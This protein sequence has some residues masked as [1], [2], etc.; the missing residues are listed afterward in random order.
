MPADLKPLHERRLICLLLVL[1]PLALFFPV[2]SHSFINFDDD[3]YVTG[4]VHVDTGLTGS[5]IT[6]AFRSG[7]AHNWHP[8]TWISHMLDC[9]LYGLN[10]AGHH[11]TNLLLHIA[12]TV[13]IFLFLHRITGALWRSGFVAALF[14]CHPIHVESVA[15][16]AERKDVL[17]TLFW[18]LTLLAYARF[19]EES[20]AQYLKFKAQSL[21]SKNPKPGSKAQSLKPRVFYSAAL[22]LFA[23][24]LMSKPMVVTLPFVLLL[25]D[26]WPFQRFTPNG[27]GVQT[28]A[29]QRIVVE[30]I[31]FFALSL[32]S[33]TV[34]F[35]A[36]RGA[37][38]T[39]DSLPLSF[40]LANAAVSCL[41]YVS[42]SIW[43][44]DLSVF[45]P[46]PTHWPPG[47][48][49]SSVIFVLA[50]SVLFLWLARRCPYLFVGWYWFLGTLIPVIGLVQVGLQSMADRYLYIPS[51]GLFL[52]IVW[53][54][55]AFSGN[56]PHKKW[57]ATGVGIAVL[58]GCATD[59]WIQLQY[60][61]NSIALFSHANAV[62]PNNDMTDNHLGEA[63]DQAGQ[64]DKAIPILRESV[65]INP[66][67]ARGFSEL[68]TALAQQGKWPEAIECFRKAV[69]LRPNDAVLHYDLGVE[70]LANDQLDEA[71]AELLTALQLNP[72]LA[73]AHRSLAAVLLKRGET[74]GALEHYS[75]A[76]K[77]N[78]GWADAH[79][80]FGLALLNNYRPAE[81]ATQFS[82][83]VALA[84]DQARGHYHLAQA[85]FRQ[86]QSQEAIDEFWKALRLDPNSPDALDE[87]AWILATDPD[88]N[89]RSGTVAIHLAERACARTHYQSAATLTTLG[90]AYAE[91]GRFPEAV[92]TARKARD[93]ASAS[94][95]K[96]LTD[97]NEQLLRLYQEQRP[98]RQSP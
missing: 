29:L 3:Q 52:A 91:A 24:G 27:I 55:N 38:A 25:L 19:V 39:L 37:V 16:V 40:R 35:L 66:Y 60:W 75:D 62:T 49:F 86:H 53:G 90:A 81:A 67:N 20:N 21:K 47:L 26:F 72:N 77:L 2:T 23:C 5:G 96:D 51:I 95:Q 48:V 88:S 57:I 68:G 22:V 44:V 56:W 1:L 84:P 13:L 15:W 14:A 61:Q 63:L 98:Y 8:L 4:N 6:W 93:L 9:Q 94:G 85:F 69:R 11:L 82:A 50:C 80:D 31:P 73:A 71:A 76:V 58:A 74:A 79:F 59:T 45:Y 34:T 43:P 7:Y 28:S 89:L 64:F 17:S 41:R 33:S 92:E 32:A 54:F 18:M 12:N 46:I 97:R 83:A 78:P 42:K 36:Q 65:R 10:P 70:L 87:L 30:K